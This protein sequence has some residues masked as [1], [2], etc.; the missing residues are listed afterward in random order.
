M[1]RKILIGNFVFAENDNKG[2]SKK[3]WEIFFA[4]DEKK[5]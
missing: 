4:V 1:F 5:K 3:N 2:I